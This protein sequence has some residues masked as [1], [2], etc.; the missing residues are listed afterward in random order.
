MDANERGITPPEFPPSEEFPEFLALLERLSLPVKMELYREVYR[1]EMTDTSG[2][3][4]QN[5][6]VWALESHLAGCGVT[7]RACPNF[8]CMDL[9]FGDSGGTGPCGRCRNVVPLFRPEELRAMRE[10]LGMTG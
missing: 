2:D 9:I 10:H 5:R 8:R 3:D 6:L 1:M 4:L 7:A